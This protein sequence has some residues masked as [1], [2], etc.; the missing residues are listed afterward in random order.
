M[1]DAC[2]KHVFVRVLC[3]LPLDFLF[4]KVLSAKSWHLRYV[5]KHQ[6]LFDWDE[7]FYVLIKS[8]YHVPRPVS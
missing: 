5:L 2:K 3:R 6:K 4:M 8:E 1:R 7:M